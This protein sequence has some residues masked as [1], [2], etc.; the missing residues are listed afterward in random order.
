MTGHAFKSRFFIILEIELK[1]IH[2]NN[3]G[4]FNGYSNVSLISKSSSSSERKFL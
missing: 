3:N 2:E 4:V 1:E